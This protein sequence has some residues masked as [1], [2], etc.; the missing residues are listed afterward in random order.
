MGKPEYN[1]CRQALLEGQKT[2]NKEDFLTQCINM[3]KHLNV[4]C[5]SYGEPKVEE[6]LAIKTGKEMT[7]QY[8]QA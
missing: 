1:L 4:K 2:C 8:L 3:C 5:V 6:K 7:T